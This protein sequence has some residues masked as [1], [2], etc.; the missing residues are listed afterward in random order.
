MF[1]VFVVKEGESCRRVVAGDNETRS[2][3]SGDVLVLAVVALVVV[4]PSIVLVR[5]VGLIVGSIWII[6]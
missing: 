5:I 4:V 1:V 6:L 2:G 3:G